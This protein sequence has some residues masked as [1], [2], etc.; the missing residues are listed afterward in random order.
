MP[1]DPLFRS[2]R[3]GRRFVAAV[4]IAVWIIAVVVIAFVPK[5][6]IIVVV[7]AFGLGNTA[8]STLLMRQLRITYERRSGSSQ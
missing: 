4:L 8:L 6:A 7:V 3:L 2:Y 5:T 1:Q